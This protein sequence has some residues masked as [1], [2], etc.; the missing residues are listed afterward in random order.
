MKKKEK[1]FKCHSKNI[2][3]FKIDSPKFKLPESYKDINFKV[4]YY[5]CLDCGFMWKSLK[6]QC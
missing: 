5:R 6:R 1:C 2:K 3:L 4:L